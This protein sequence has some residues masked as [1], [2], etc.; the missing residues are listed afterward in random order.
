VRSFQLRSLQPLGAGEEVTI[1]YGREKPNCDLLRDYGFTLPGNPHDRLKF[2][3]DGSSSSSSSSGVSSSRQERQQASD[4]GVHGLNAASV[5]EVRGGC[6]GRRGMHEW[7]VQDPHTTCAM[8]ALR[9]LPHPCLPLRAGCRLC[10][11]P[12]S[13]QDRASGTGGS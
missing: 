6:C 12:R 10:R 3:C 2:G 8:C 1:S 11:R 4:G 13:R 5:L 7:W 9:L